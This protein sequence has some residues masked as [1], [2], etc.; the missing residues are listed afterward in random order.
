MGETAH[1]MY[2]IYKVIR[3]EIDKYHFLSTIFWKI[4]VLFRPEIRKKLVADG[5]D[6]VVEG[7]PRSANTFFAAK[8]SLQQSNA[9]KIASHLHCFHQIRIA[10]KKNIPI[11]IL[12]R[13]PL[14]AVA[15]E[16]LRNRKSSI[17]IM[18]KEYISFYSQLL[19]LTHSVFIILFVSAIGDNKKMLKEFNRRNKTCLEYKELE[20]GLL[21]DEVRG[22]DRAEFILRDRRRTGVKIRPE[23]VALPDKRKAEILETIREKIRME[24]PA[25]LE[26]ATEIYEK[27]AKNGYVEDAKG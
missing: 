17:K 10:N 15:S 20:E 5:T 2:N 9:I 22:R 16:Y 11:I 8:V 6:L 19:P 7:F 1:K 27:L 4:L 25:Q 12:L 26:I 24:C 21:F 13:D 18:L 14:D 23:G 3:C